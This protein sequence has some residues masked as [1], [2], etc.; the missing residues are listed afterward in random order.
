MALAL[1]EQLFL[2]RTLSVPW[3]APR[4]RGICAPVPMLSSVWGGRY[5]PFHVRS[6]S[7]NPLM[8]L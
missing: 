8:L 5:R 1:Q 3:P 4:R 7:I 2:Q 6:G